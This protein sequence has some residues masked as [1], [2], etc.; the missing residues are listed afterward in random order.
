MKEIFNGIYKEENRIFTKNLLPGKNVYGEKIIKIGKDEFR[1][2]NPYRSK[3]CAFILK[4]MKFFPL[5]KKSRI[6]YLGVANGTTASHFS[7]ITRDGIIYGVEIAF[8]PMKKFVK[9][10]QER[11]NMVPIMGDANKPE[12]YEKIVDEIDFLYQDI[13]Q[14]NQIEIFL[15]NIDK[16]SPKYGMI[17]IKARSIDIAEKPKKIFEKVRKKIEVN[18][19]IIEIIELSPYAK[20]HVAMSLKI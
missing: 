5:N 8:K 19:E 1:A 7:D 12:E 6:L 2:W 18:H 15:K 10:C 3:M 16:F 17:M 11:N 9:L 20:D 14:K 13:A 4:G